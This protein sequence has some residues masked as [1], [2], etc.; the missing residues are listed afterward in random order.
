MKKLFT[1]VALAMCSMFI[2]PVAV[3]AATSTVKAETASPQIR[4][5]ADHGVVI[6]VFDDG[7]HV[8]IDF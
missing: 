7:S 8:I 2:A 5:Q 6:I 1:L 3:K 4:N